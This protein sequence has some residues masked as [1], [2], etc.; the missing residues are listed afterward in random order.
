M[1]LVMPLPVLSILGFIISIACIV[2]MFSLLLRG[3]VSIRVLT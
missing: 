2:V 1:F 3:M